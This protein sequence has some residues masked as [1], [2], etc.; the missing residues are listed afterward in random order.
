MIIL[1]VSPTDRIAEHIQALGKVSRLM[2]NQQFRAA[3]YE[4]GSSNDLY[5]LFRKA[6][7]GVAT[8][9]A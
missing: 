3:C 4:A 5:D 2:T 7:G 1:L 6:E 8:P 9:Q